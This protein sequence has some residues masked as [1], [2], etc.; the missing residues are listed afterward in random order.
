MC[1]IAGSSAGHRTLFPELLNP[2][3]TEP[4]TFS[5]GRSGQN[6]F[7]RSATELILG[8]EGLV[9]RSHPGGQI[10]EKWYA[11]T[12]WQPSISNSNQPEVPPNVSPP[13]HLSA[14]NATEIVPE[15]AYVYLLEG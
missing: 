4:E 15:N 9:F 10:W 2:R 3:Q 12:E 7:I 13:S 1:I 14:T 8:T 11:P 5:T 6:Q